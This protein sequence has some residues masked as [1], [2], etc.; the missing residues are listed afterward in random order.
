MTRR[1]VKEERLLLSLRDYSC[2]TLSEFYY[3]LIKLAA[4]TTKYRFRLFS[5]ENLNRIANN[6]VSK[7]QEVSILFVN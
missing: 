7:G 1:L 4:F 5:N 3:D 6:V 2:A